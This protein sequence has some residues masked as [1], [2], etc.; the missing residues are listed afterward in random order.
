MEMQ[1]VDTQRAYELLWDKI[2]TLELAPGAPI[3]E[4]RLAVDLDLPAAVAKHLDLV[5]AIRAGDTVAAAEI[6]RD[7]VQE[8]YDKVREAR[9][10]RVTV[11]YGAD[12]RSVMVEDDA[13]LSGAIIATGL[14]L[15]QPC[16]GRGTCLKCKVMAE[17]ALSPLDEHELHGLTTAERAAH[18][19]LA[20]RARV[21]GDVAVTLAP[22][23]VYSNK[24]FRASNDHKRKGVPLGLAIDFGSTT[25]A[26]FVTTLDAGKV[27]VGAAVLNQQTAFGADVISRLAAA[28]RGPET[29]ERISVLALSSIVQAVDALKLAPGIKER[30]RKV[31]I[32]GNCA[33]HHLML[34]YPVE[35]LAELPFQPYR[36]EAVR[37]RSGDGAQS[38]AA[39]PFADIFPAGVEV[40]LLPLIG[41]FVGSD[42]LACLAYYNFDRATGPMA[43]IDLGTNGEVMVTDGRGQGERGGRHAGADHHR[44]PTARGA[45]RLGAARTDLRAAPGGRDRPQRSLRPRSPDLRAAHQRGRGQGA[46]FPDHRPGGGSAR[47]GRRRR[48]RGGLALPDAARRPG[49]A[50]GEGRDQGCNRDAVG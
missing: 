31:T 8:F 24:I 45:D 10:A 22:I 14:S 20:C 50:E 1:R 46:P 48:G 3:D 6:M 19:R 35:T 41:G 25:V 49:A 40:A 9:T 34:R 2:T 27:C 15:E 29:A 21:L 42:A 18:Y 5:E 44:G 33:M 37:F 30:I 32:V 4:Q 11:S 7:H 16:A 36:K 43:A 28:Q 12:V 13:L 23:V 38:D 26:A 39:N 17:G 47:G